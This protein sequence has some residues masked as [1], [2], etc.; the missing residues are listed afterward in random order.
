MALVVARGRVGS[1]D[2]PLEDVDPP[3]AP[4]RVVPDG[5]FAK[6]RVGV[7]EELGGHRLDAGRGSAGSVHHRAIIAHTERLFTLR[8]EP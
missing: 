1:V 4:F 2:D 5:P 7:D 8:C 6:G 3:E